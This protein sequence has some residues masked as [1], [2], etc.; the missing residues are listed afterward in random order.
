MAKPIDPACSVRRDFVVQAAVAFVGVGSLISLWPFIDQMNPNP[1]SLRDTID[2]DL[3]PIEP[4]QI[5]QVQWK[6]QPILIHHRT[7]EEIAR[8][9][10]VGLSSLIDPFARVTGL[11]EDAPAIDA[12]RTKPGHHAWLVVAGLCTYCGCLI[13]PA[14]DFTLTGEAFLCPWCAS[15][16]DA[17]GR[18]LAGPAPRNLAVPRYEFLAPFKI[19][20]R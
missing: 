7:P 3:T 20:L 11:P 1:S 16:F 15:R 9:Q 8:A 6:G 10:K 19:R 18:V 2:V 13:R 14:E 12:N 17:L 4:G 5:K